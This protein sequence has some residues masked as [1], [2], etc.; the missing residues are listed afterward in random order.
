M[1]LGHLLSIFSLD[2]TAPFCTS[3]CTSKE[4][5]TFLIVHARKNNISLLCILYTLMPQ[6][7]PLSTLMLVCK[8]YYYSTPWGCMRNYGHNLDLLIISHYVK[9]ESL[10]NVILDPWHPLWL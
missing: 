6:I 9:I 7:I 2:L 4:Q 8:W 1:K 10:E 3:T 5:I